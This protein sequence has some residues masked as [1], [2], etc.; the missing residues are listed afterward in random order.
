MCSK[1]GIHKVENF[2]YVTFVSVLLKG[3][4]FP[5]TYIVFFNH[6]KLFLFLHLKN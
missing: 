3:N 2:G 4:Y 5:K 1:N 6:F